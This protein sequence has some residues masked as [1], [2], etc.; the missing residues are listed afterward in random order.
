[1]ICDKGNRDLS[2]KIFIAFPSMECPKI[3]WTVK[4]KKK[5][6]NAKFEIEENT[7]LQIARK[8]PL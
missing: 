7:K 1:M 6:H 8:L 2:R 3:F 4:H 5:I